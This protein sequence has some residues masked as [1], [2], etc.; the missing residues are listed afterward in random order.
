MAGAKETPR[1][2]MIGLVYLALTALLAMNITST[3]LDKFVFINKS[4]ERTVGDD[5]SKNDLTIGAINT[6]VSEAG[7]RA[8]DVAVLEKARRVRTET[9]SVLRELTQLKDT[10]I[11]ITGGLTEDG[12]VKGKTDVETVANYMINKGNGKI[13]QDRLNAYVDFLKNES[14]IN[15]ERLTYFALDAADDPMFRDDPAQRKKDFANLKF[16]KTPTVA[17]IADVTQ[18]MT[19]VLN[20]ESFVLEEL[21]RQVGAGDIKFDNI[22][23]MVR[24]ES[25]YVAAGTKYEADF[26][27]AASMSSVVPQM[28]INGNPINVTNGIGKVEFTAT[29]GGYDANGQVR[30]T[31][32]GEIT[33]PRP[34]GDTTFIQE[35]E[36]FVVQPV[37]QIQ[38]ATIQRLYLNAGNE[39]NIQVPALGAAYN[40]RITATGATVIDGPTKGLVTV[41]P[42]AAKVTLSISSDGTLIDTKDFDVSRIPVPKVQAVINN[43][44]ADTRIGMPIAQVRALRMDAI[45]EE[46]FRSMLPNDARYRVAE[47]EVTLARRQTAVRTQKFT[48]NEADLSQLMAQAQAGDRLVIEVKRVQRR[49]FREATEDVNIGTEFITIPLN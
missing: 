27:L 29:G 17:G 1:Q 25:K 20:R 18:M 42:N 31:Y 34:G 28:K 10:F 32:R 47:F 16:L 36:Y 6:A 40:P 39:L 5:R 48:S 3:V 41:V 21:R 44:P 24:A 49:N 38:S 23:P 30:R 26:F 11:E 33:I 43:R 35:F 12:A 45:A 15:G 2:R 4:L 46:N 13:L 19:E 7:N 14:G 9:E 37:V 8:Q 22:I